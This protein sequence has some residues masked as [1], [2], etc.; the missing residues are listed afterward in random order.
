VAAGNYSLTAKA[1]DN[2]SLVTTSPAVSVSVN[3]APTVSITSPVTNTSFEAPASVTIKATAADADGSITKVA[4]YNG[5][6]LL[7]SDNTS[8]YSFTWNNVATGN[9]SLTAKATDNGLLVTTS[10]AVIVSVIAPGAP[11]VRI[12]SPAANA[13]FSAPA[14]ITINATATVDKGTVREVKF[15]QGTTLLHTATKDPY[16]WT[17]QNVPAGNYTLLAKATDN[18]GLTTTSVGVPISVTT[19]LARSMVSTTTS[20]TEITDFTANSTHTND[21]KNQKSANQLISLKLSPNPASNDLYAFTTGLQPNKKLTLS[22]FSESGMLVKTMQSA[23]VNQVIKVDISSLRRG[24][25][26]LKVVGEDGVLSKQFVK[27]TDK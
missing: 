15:Y 21:I 16:T 10:S 19:T 12:T 20:N 22:I 9:Y 23:A 2:S 18:N 11:T 27:I 5:S 25:Y 3:A 8:P 24:V 7:G 4:F 14:T 6:T 1:T 26:T 13:Q 17:W